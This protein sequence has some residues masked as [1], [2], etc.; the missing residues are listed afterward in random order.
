VLWS[1]SNSIAIAT[2]PYNTIAIPEAHHNTVAIQ[3]IA[4]YCN[5]IY[6]NQGLVKKASKNKVARCAS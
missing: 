6:L 1:V 3:S 5:T 4:I 2:P